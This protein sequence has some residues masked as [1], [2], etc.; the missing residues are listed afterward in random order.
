MPITPLPT[1]SSRQFE[2]APTRPRRRLGTAA[3]LTALAL[4]A[5]ACGSA[6][7]HPGA[8][9][10]RANLPRASAHGVSTGTAAAA[11]D[12]LAV[13]LYR[14][15]DGGGGNLV[16]SPYSIELAMAMAR[17]GAKGDTRM[18]MDEVLGAP[19]GTA[20]DDSLNALDQALASR[21]GTFPSDPATGVGKGTLSLAVADRIWTQKGLG[22]EAPFLDLLA[23][24]YGAG[25]APID[26]A[27]TESA[28]QTI[29][30]WVADQT[31][32]KIQDLVP[33]GGLSSD[34]RIALV[35]ALYFK[36][37]WDSKFDPS[38]NQP[39]T[40]ADGR[41]VSVPTITGGEHG[42]YGSGPGWKAAEIH[43]IGGHLGMVVIEPDDLASFERS[44]TVRTL[45]TITSS[46]HDNLTSVRMPTFKFDQQFDLASTLAD[47]GMHDAFDAGLADLSGMTTEEQLYLAHVYHQAYI[48]VD[49]H[50]TEAAAATAVFAYASAAMGG[51]ALVVDHPF[52]F[53]IRDDS[54]GA[55]LFL[56][57]VTDPTTSS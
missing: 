21:P 12:A 43:Y 3:V 11:T 36:A 45:N 22:F 23:T 30:G 20:L 52:L 51:E 48:S 46:L 19:S 39:F 13:A 10:T 37:P 28:R 17:V 4:V 57:R 18:Q 8:V 31:K 16:F 14:K 27:E 44:L 55:L 38:S 29:N 42:T 33:K 1:P 47:L 32:G 49:E 54:T 25:V 40:T 35:N 34:A 7:S 5:G 50:G 53:A 6:N 2:A 41:S 24:D 26:F 9:E 15:L 56:G